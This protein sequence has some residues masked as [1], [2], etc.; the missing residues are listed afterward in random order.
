MARG[1]SGSSVVWIV[2]AVAIA[3][4]A[5]WLSSQVDAAQAQAAEARL[6]EQQL[7]AQL[8]QLAAQVDAR[9]RDGA[10]QD[11]A[12]EGGADNLVVAL[13]RRPDLIP[14]E[15]QVGGRFYFLEDTL[16]VLSDRYAYVACEDGH[17][18]CHMLLAYER[19]DDAV[20]FDVID[21]Y[22]D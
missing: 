2:V 8:Q 9:S 4:Y 14:F 10:D 5:A 22:Q 11:G 20:E 13:L 18:M 12:G 7:V 3:A 21:A 17:V 19:T 16:R 6:R 15:P 1:V